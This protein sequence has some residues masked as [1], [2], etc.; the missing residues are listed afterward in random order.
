M[1]PNRGPSSVRGPELPREERSLNLL[2][3]LCAAPPPAH[4]RWSGGGRGS[5][6]HIPPKR[7]NP[8]C[9]DGGRSRDSLNRR[10]F[11]LV[12][13]SS[14]NWRRWEGG[15]DTL[16]YDCQPLPSLERTSEPHPL[17]PIPYT[18][19]LL[20]GSCVKA[21]EIREVLCPPSSEY[22]APQRGQVGQCWLV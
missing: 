4:L 18:Y 13:T 15:G 3:V 22:S 2:S 8:D 7:E 14:L 11:P 5:S 17:S 19:M 12:P 20:F 1:W 9:S 10:L 21:V 16:S 6:P